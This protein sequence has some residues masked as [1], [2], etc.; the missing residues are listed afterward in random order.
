MTD[1]KKQSH[2]MLILVCLLCDVFVRPFNSGTQI[3]ARTSIIGAII[4]F[5]I[6]AILAALFLKIS[7]SLNSRFIKWCL[8]GL[9]FTTS[10]ATIVKAE[11]FYRF[12]SDKQ[13]P[14]IIF[15]AVFIGVIAYC[16][17]MPQ[18]ALSRSAVAVAF[19]SILTVGLII[20][21][22]FKDIDFQ[23]LDVNLNSDIINSALYHFNFSA[24]ILLFYVLTSKTS[25]KRNS[26]TVV[27][28]VVLII[29]CIL[30]I[31]GEAVMGNAAVLQ[32]QIVNT[33]SK[34]G[35][36]SVFK[37][38]DVFYS[39]IWLMGMLIKAIA[40]YVYGLNLI[41]NKSILKQAFSM[42]AFIILIF[43]AYNISYKVFLAA[44]NIGSIVVAIL[45]C[46][47]SLYERRKARENAY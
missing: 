43:A 37:R 27:L 41:D 16:S 46:A 10:S 23:R 34:I 25:E 5:C 45:I 17:K 3:N 29:F 18:N 35:S 30:V 28:L 6:F 22:N 33:L 47:V 21:S 8:I 26:F 14:V 20:I 40:F 9:F 7:T 4:G 1:A 19:L 39:A 38:L 44:I 42:A 13:L 15:S 11:Q 12:I 32:T 31:L 2:F 24:E 36:I